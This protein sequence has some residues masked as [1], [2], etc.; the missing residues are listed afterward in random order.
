MHA[1]PIDWSSRL[2]ARAT[3]HRRRRKRH[4]NRP[5]HVGKCSTSGAMFF[6][7]IDGLEERAN[8]VP[9]AEKPEPQAIGARHQQAARKNVLRESALATCGVA[10]RM[11]ISSPGVAAGEGQVEC[12]AAAVPQAGV[13]ISI[14]HTGRWLTHR[15]RLRR[16]LSKLG[17][18]APALCSKPKRWA[19]RASSEV[20]ARADI[21]IYNLHFVPRVYPPAFNHKH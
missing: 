10:Q 11:S 1:G 9:N 7:L 4:G 20:W 14:Y 5:S 2:L 3:S 17:S 21:C 15:G 6:I 18:W 13:I 8:R 19:C 16:P 12:G